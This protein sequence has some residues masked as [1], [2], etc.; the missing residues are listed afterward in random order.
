MEV[1]KHNLHGRIIWPKGTTPLTVH[2]LRNWLS[3]L[4]K[5]LGQWSM[6][7]LGKGYFEFIFTSLE[8][9][10]R[11]RSLP[12]WNLNPGFL[13]LFAW[14]KDFNPSLQ[15]SSTAQVWVRLHGLS[16][17]YWRPRIFFVIASSVGTPICTDSASS[18]PMIER[19]FGQ[20]AK[21]VVDMDVTRELRDNVLVERKG[22]AFF[23]ELEYE[24]LL[25]IVFIARKLVTMWKSASLLTKNH[26][27]KRLNHQGTIIRHQKR[28]MFKWKME[29]IGGKWQRIPLLWK[30]HLELISMMQENWSRR[31]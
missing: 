1:C 17:E 2:D 28:Y 18:K 20:F 26:H 29:G 31:V 27:M 15:N 21:V 9:V 14:S 23:V 19:T 3:N 8:D 24:N 13:K 12:S 10:K 25:I 7:S 6:S 4:W 16:Q 22:F 30:R 5:N 11:V